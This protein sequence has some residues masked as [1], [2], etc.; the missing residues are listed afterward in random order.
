MSDSITHTRWAWRTWH[1]TAVM[2]FANGALIGM[3]ATQIPAFKERLGLEPLALSL[4]LLT[5]AGGTALAMACSVWLIQRLGVVGSIR[6]SATL[7][8]GFGILIPLAPSAVTLAMVALLF[9]AAGGTM[10]VAMNANASDV[11]RRSERPYMSS[12]HGMWS[13]GGFAGAGAGAPLLRTFSPAIEALIVSVAIFGLFLWA[14][15]GLVS[16]RQPAVN[17]HAAGKARLAVTR[18]A[19]VLGVMAIFAFSCEGVVL[20]W[21]A[22]YMKQTLGADSNLA[23]MGYTAFACSMAIVRFAGDSIRHKFSAR[24][25]IGMGGLIAAFGLAIG[26]LS[27]SAEIM[28]IGCAIAGAGIANVAPVLFSLA[29][30]RARP[31]AH[32]ATVS[33]L[34]F[35]GMLAAPPLLGSIA[36]YFGLGA[37][38]YAGAAAVTAI[39]LIAVSGIERVR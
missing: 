22:V 3:W 21:A 28:N 17:G 38:F 2:F 27:R 15:R 1:P 33:T 36:Q 11:E 32:I 23:L 37:I 39:A 16:S 29:G 9:G 5:L 34:G 30:A 19:L 24:V 26:P 14:Q 7:Y 35:C 10:N 4:V 12:F 13:L 6:V 18:P 8:C 20:D 25:L 31:E